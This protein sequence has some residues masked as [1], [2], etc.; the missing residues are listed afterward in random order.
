MS[1]MTYDELA[2]SDL[3][4]V[5]EEKDARIAELENEQKAWRVFT[6]K[7][8]QTC[9]RL[10]EHIAELEDKYSRCRSSLGSS[11]K[12]S[13]RLQGRIA[14]LEKENARLRQRFTMFLD[15]CTSESGEPWIPLKRDVVEARQALKE[16]DE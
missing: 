9:G 13:A 4:D 12:T 5:C 8:N 15:R 16:S 11:S 1:D 14:E 2:Y 3:I 6:D 7:A 10:E